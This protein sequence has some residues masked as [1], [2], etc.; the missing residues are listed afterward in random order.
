MQPKKSA[1]C[2]VS[3][4]QQI[5]QSNIGF[6]LA[7][8]KNNVKITNFQPNAKIFNFQGHDWNFPILRIFFYF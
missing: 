7:S 2:C 8:V 1:I 5:S 6:F 3:K 4:T